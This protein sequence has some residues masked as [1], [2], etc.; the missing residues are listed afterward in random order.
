MPQDSDIYY[1]ALADPS[2]PVHGAGGPPSE[3]HPFLEEDEV[4]TC[5][6]VSDD[7]QLN[8]CGSCDAWG[9]S[10]HDCPHFFGLEKVN[11][12]DAETRGSG[13]HC[14]GNIDFEDIM[15]NTIRGAAIKDDC[16]CLIYTLRQL[17]EP[18]AC[19]NDIREI[20]MGIFKVGPDQVSHCQ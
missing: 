5:L 18:S 2:V 13:P 9:H 11:H 16:N 10:A 15:K 6:P 20:L 14:R 12:Q 1:D 7:E 8:N 19:V 17:I 3:E 4:L